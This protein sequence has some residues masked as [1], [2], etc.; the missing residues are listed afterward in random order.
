MNSFASLQKA[1]IFLS[2]ASHPSIFCRDTII[3]GGK[4]AASGRKVQVSVLAC[5]L[6]FYLVGFSETDD[7]YFSVLHSRFF[8]KDAL[9][10]AGFSIKISIAKSHFP[11]P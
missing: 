10:M 7:A 11:L 5:H 6:I 9:Q 1:V 2:Q 3:G 4:V 8:M